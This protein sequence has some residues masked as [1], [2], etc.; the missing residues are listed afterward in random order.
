MQVEAVEVNRTADPQLKIA[1]LLKTW[2]VSQYREV[3][4]YRVTVTTMARE[5]GSTLS[6]VLLSQYSARQP[7]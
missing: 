4:D 2:L 3:K 6:P 7:D 5:K 1:K